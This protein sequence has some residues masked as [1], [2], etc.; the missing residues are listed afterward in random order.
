MRPFRREQAIG[1]PDRPTL[2]LER[3]RA[4]V[5]G[6]SWPSHSFSGLSETL[7]WF[8]I[9]KSAMGS[10]TTNAYRTLV[11]NGVSAWILATGKSLTEPPNTLHLAEYGK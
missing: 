6:L 11:M 8:P 7:P 2:H 9:I 10:S 1:Q 3:N 4:D 5:R